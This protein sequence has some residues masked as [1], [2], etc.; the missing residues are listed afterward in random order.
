MSQILALT[1]RVATLEE[2]I[3]N[4][5]ALI[6]DLQELVQGNGDRKRKRSGETRTKRALRYGGKAM[7]ALKQDFYLATGEREDHECMLLGC[8]T[9]VDGSRTAKFYIHMKNNHE[10]QFR[11]LL[12]DDRYR[13]SN[14]GEVQLL[15]EKFEKRGPE[16]RPI[17]K[18][19]EVDLLDV[20]E[21]KPK[22]T[23]TRRTRSRRGSDDTLSS[24]TGS[25]RIAKQSTIDGEGTSCDE[26]S[27]DE[28]PKLEEGYIKVVPTPSQKSAAEALKKLVMA[29]ISKRGTEKFSNGD[30]L[31]FYKLTDKTILENAYLLGQTNDLI[32]RSYGQDAAV[33]VPSYHIVV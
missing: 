11:F 14:N 18:R 29:D 23:L 21:D 1:T 20:D 26:W 24:S 13:L 25:T 10:E 7:V 8:K 15:I 3:Q 2:R 31:S 28:E 30:G 19:S 32:E 16:T 33:A 6:A 17:L 12:R 27:G 5:G 22:P 9:V 4:N